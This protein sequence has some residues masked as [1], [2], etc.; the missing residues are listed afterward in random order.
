MGI[1]TTADKVFIRR[2]W[3]L[4]PGEIRPD[5][6]YLRPLLSQEDAGKW[7][8]LEHARS[9]KQVLYTHEVVDGRRRTIRFDEDS[10][11]WRYFEAHRERLE[12]R[13]YVVDAGRRWYEIWV[14][15]NPA[16]WELP[17]IVFPDISPDARFF[18]DRLGCIVDGNCYWITTNELGDE[19]LLLL[20]LGVANSKLM[21]RY[22]DLVFQNKLYSQ[23]RRHLTQYV[24]KYPLPDRDQAASR[25]IAEAVADLVTDSI[26]RH[27]ERRLV[28]KVDRLVAEAFG[29]DP[30]LARDTLD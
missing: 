22:H 27:D 7:R 12:G 16:E 10:S 19:E 30:S 15:Q 29:M 17:K 2:D 24:A 18:L 6:K 8:P 3:Q 21:A 14:P 23:R 9:P 5:E 26:G 25:K 1:K 11:T 4:L 13:K 28:N 20:M